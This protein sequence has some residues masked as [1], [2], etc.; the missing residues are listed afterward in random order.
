MP[1]ETNCHYHISLSC[2]LCH[3]STYFSYLLHVYCALAILE[4]TKYA[5]YI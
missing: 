4:G 2:L 3:L 1:L 5:L